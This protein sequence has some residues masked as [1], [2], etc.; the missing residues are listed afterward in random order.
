MPETLSFELHT[1]T[2]RLDRAADRIL[3]T[4]HG[5]SYRRFRTLLSVHLLSAESPKVVTQ[6]AVAEELG[7]S[8]PSASRMTGV[9]ATAGLLDVHQDPS[10]GNR[11]RLRLTPAG[12]DLVDRCRTLLEK[13]FVDV[14]RRSGVSYADY[15]RDTRR[16]LATLGAS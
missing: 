15:A 10:G 16:L 11:K 8:E 1:L 3:R 4:E 9:L 13:R 7:I 6:R 12:A 2:A 14:V 5:L